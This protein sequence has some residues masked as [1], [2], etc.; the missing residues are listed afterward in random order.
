MDCQ[1]QVFQEGIPITGYFFTSSERRRPIYNNHGAFNE[2]PM[3]ALR[4]L[5]QA[6]P[7]EPDWI[8]WYSS[9]A[10]YSDYFMKRGS[11][12]AAPFH[13]VPNAVYRKADM[14]AHRNEYNR[15]F[16]MIQYN[17]GTQ[18]NENYA[19]RTFP[20]WDGELF[21]GGTS[22][23]LSGSWALAEASR[24]R[25]DEAG[26]H[27]VGKQLEWTFGR[28]P[29]DQTLMYGV[30]YNFTPQFAYCTK[31]IVGSLPVGMDSMKDDEPYWHGSAYATSKEM[32]I[33]PVNRFM[34]T[35]ATYMET[36]VPQDAS[37]SF[38]IEKEVSKDSTQK[39]V[40][41]LNGKGTHQLDIRLFNATADFASQ[42]VNLTE[43]Q[44]LRLDVTLQIQ[45]VNK[46]YV[47]VVVADGN[48]LTMAEV[49][50]ACY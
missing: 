27:L 8:K 23:H 16:N 50:G 11:E 33:A 26:M 34:G 30:G 32:W 48:T 20:I 10:I 9:A 2:A 17:D 31:N 35:V 15:K 14:L 4:T 46:P 37:I 49:N 5:C 25:N 39:A 42:Q 21:H 41:V 47:A 28:N 18:L 1:E 29:F 43:G 24:L 7:E 36:D 38:R 6:F 22:C 13:L 19:I 44:E 40:L 45:D 12:I 3:L